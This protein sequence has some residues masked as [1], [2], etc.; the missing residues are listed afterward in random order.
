[1]KRREFCSAAGA[2]AFAVAVSATAKTMAN[3]GSLSVRP[4]PGGPLVTPRGEFFVY[5][6]MRTPPE[7]AAS[8]QFD[9]LV[10]RPRRY[11]EADLAAMPHQRGVWTDECFVNRAGGPLIFTPAFAGV[12]LSGLMQVLAPSPEARAVRIETN[13]GHPPFLLPFSE[14]KR[15]GALLVATMGHAPVP[16]RH[17][18]P[19]TRIFVP[20]AGGNHHP[21]WVNRVTFIAEP[22]P[23]HPA[24]AL[25]GFLLPSPPE[26]TGSLAG[27][28]LSGYA[29]AGPEPVASVEFSTDAGRTWR[30]MPLPAQPDPFLWI[31]WQV[32]WK[33]P[34]RGFYV[35]RVRAT[36][37]GGDHQATPGTLA[38]EVR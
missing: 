14:L 2:A 1:M 22:A 10:R 31:T 36:G 25:A 21:K 38:V 29:F 30:R 5:S 16:L 28:E 19:Y 4:T 15:P 33:P 3:P 34:E 7:R 11:S 8:I 20:G 27:V 6:Q 24:P 35:L 23:E 37:A 32:H 9:G 13:D 26:V 12:S 17:G 18:S